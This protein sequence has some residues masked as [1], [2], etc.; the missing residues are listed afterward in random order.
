MIDLHSHILPGLDDGPQTLEECA[1]ML[2]MAAEAGTT[3]IVATPHA[4]LQFRFQPELIEEKI[5][6]LGRA[7]GPILRIHR[8]CD[9]HLSY[10]NIQD[11]LA[12]PTRYTINQKNYLLVE[13]SDL[14]IA[15]TIDEILFRLREAGITP[16]VTHPERNWLLQQRVEQLHTWVLNGCLI[17]VTAQSFWGRFGPEARR[18]CRELM[19]RDLVHFV[20]SDAHD[21]EDRPPRLDTAYQHIAKKYGE[22]RAQRL[23]VKNP[24]TVLDGAPWECEPV[25]EPAKRPR[26]WHQFWA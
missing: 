21:C 2:R 8:G 22:E 11:A 26:K 24:R 23:L 10:D 25:P 9:F 18:F 20:A 17:Q 19:Q 15:K 3:D 12:N 6:E 16:I 7:C 4:N 5:A 13:F 14:L 1:A